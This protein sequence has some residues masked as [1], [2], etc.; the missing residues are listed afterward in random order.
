[1]KIPRTA[2][3]FA[4]PDA[5]RAAGIGTP[6][7]VLRLSFG[8][9]PAHAHDE[10]SRWRQDVLGQDAALPSITRDQRGL[11]AEARLRARNRT[12]GRDGDL[13]GPGSLGAFRCRPSR[14]G[15]RLPF[16][17]ELGRRLRRDQPN[18]APRRVRMPA[19]HPQLSWRNL[20]SCLVTGT[21]TLCT[22]KFRS[23]VRTPY[24]VDRPLI[25]I[26]AV[27]ARCSERRPALVGSISH[28]QSVALGPT[29]CCRS[30]VMSW[31]LNA[32]PVSV[33]SILSDALI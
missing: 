1:M 6:G 31:I 15:W 23:K 13:A 10:P 18:A 30:S 7:A 8:F 20:V 29:T 27:S 12:A 32:P 25:L 26:N 19:I 17:S 16:S 24:V 11:R 5:R 28:F 14:R 4:N 22:V 9:T 3:P 21:G 2:L 33:A